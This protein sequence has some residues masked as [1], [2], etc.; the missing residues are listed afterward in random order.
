MV[1]RYVAS[2]VFYPI[3]PCMLPSTSPYSTRRIPYAVPGM[4]A[5]CALACLMLCRACV[6]S[7]RSHALCYAAHACAVRAR[8]PY[9]IQSIPGYACQCIGYASHSIRDY[10]FHCIPKMRRPHADLMQSKAS[11]TMLPNALDMLSKAS[12]DMP[13]DALDMLANASPSITHCVACAI[14]GMRARTAHAYP[15][16]S[17]AC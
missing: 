6:R 1:H 14:L 15:M 7:A 10:A 2:G 5:Q 12:G 8:M 11:G 16:L 17:R 4:R 3:H 9:A 13:P